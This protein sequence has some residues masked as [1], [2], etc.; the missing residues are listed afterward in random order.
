MNIPE[1]T[2]HEEVMFFDTDCAGVVNNI[3][4]LRMVETCR[5]YLGAKMGLDFKSMQS[6]QLY[7]AVIRTEIDYRVPAVLGDKLKIHG[8]LEQLERARFWCAFVITRVCDDRVLVICRQSL[9]MVQMGKDKP[10][11]PTR[12]PSEWISQWG[13]LLD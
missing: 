8:K 11:R 7:P 4:Y 12:L 3:A 13:V 1:F 10:A 2:T 9:S 6:S 5:T